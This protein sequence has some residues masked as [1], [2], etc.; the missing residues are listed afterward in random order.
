M[1][2]KRTRTCRACGLM[3]DNIQTE[4]GRMTQYGQ[5]ESDEPY[6][7]R[8]VPQQET[9]DANFSKCL[10]QPYWDLPSGKVCRAGGFSR[11]EPTHYSLNR[12]V[13]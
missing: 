1:G 6:R 4:V 10:I 11:S 2:G 12:W 13:K 7:M 8:T 5:R 9:A 3:G